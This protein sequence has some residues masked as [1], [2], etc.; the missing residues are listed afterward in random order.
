[1][2]GAHSHLD[3]TL[4]NKGSQGGRVLFLLSDVDHLIFESHFQEDDQ[5]NDTHFWE[6]LT[7][8]KITKCKSFL[9]YL[10]LY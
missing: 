1:M 6:T 4:F 7:N 3:F 5:L 10:M 8:L 9:N 2:V